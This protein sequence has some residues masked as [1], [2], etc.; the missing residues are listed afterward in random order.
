MIRY[1]FHIIAC[2]RLAVAPKVQGDDDRHM[3]SAEASEAKTRAQHSVCSPAH[4]LSYFVHAHIPTR[5]VHIL[6]CVSIDHSGMRIDVRSPGVMCPELYAGSSTQH[7]VHVPQYLSAIMVEWVH[8]E[9]D[10]TP[11]TLSFLHQRRS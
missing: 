4:T 7:T 9:V 10:H 11:R 8:H 2:T 5:F 1:V 3:T 6:V